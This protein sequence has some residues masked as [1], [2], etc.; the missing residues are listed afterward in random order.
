MTLNRYIM[1]SGSREDAVYGMRYANVA[2]RDDLRQ[3]ERGR[4]RSSPLPE[5]LALNV[6]PIAF[7]AS[8]MTVGCVAYDGD[9][10]YRTLRER[11]RKTHVFRYDN[12]TKCIF[13]LG[14]TP[15][16]ASVGK[17]LEVN[18]EDHLLLL[19]KV[20]QQALLRWLASRRTIIRPSRPLACW[21][22]KDAALL[23]KTFEELGLIPHDGLEVVV[24]HSFDTRVLK[25]N[26]NGATPLLA[27]V[28]DVNTSNVVL[29]PV[30]SLI[31]LGLE[32]V[33]RY[34]CRREEAIDEDILPRLDALGRI[35]GRA[36]P[37]PH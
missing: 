10:E 36:G 17:A 22:R 15:A 11:H 35:T 29:T 13:N 25:P 3:A 30:G 20:I 33:G 9:D 5:G 28:M 32:V 6:A 14:L 18:T 2:G 21:G 24:R 27:L 34:V 23:S 37:C 26:G 7:S 12:R 8:R 1:R 31:E 4:V 16:T 19:G